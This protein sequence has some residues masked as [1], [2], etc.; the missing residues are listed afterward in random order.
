VPRCVSVDEGDDEL[1]QVVASVASLWLW[2]RDG[3]GGGEVARAAG[4]ALSGVDF[5][6]V[7]GPE[8]GDGKG[9]RYNRCAVRG[10]HSW[11]C[12]AAD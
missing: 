2:S 9:G 4:G 8:L 6:V 1:C 11:E 3:G 12:C 10:G 7:E 5:E